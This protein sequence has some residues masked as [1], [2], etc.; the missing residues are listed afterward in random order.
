MAVR[1]SFEQRHKYLFGT[2]GLREDDYLYISKVLNRYGAE[3]IY[4]AGEFEFSTIEELVGFC[5]KKQC[6][7]LL[8]LGTLSKGKIRFS[9]IIG[10]SMSIW[11]VDNPT[12]ASPEEAAISAQTFNEI[13]AR[14]KQR[15]DFIPGFPWHVARNTLVLLPLLLLSST[16]LVPSRAPE[17]NSIFQIT[18]S[19]AFIHYTWAWVERRR[20]NKSIFVQRSPLALR[21]VKMWPEAL[22][23]IFGAAL[24]P[25]CN[26][27]L[28]LVAEK[29]L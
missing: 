25:I 9:L 21:L 11:E 24:G 26:F 2:K 10:G 22:L 23:V 1:R 13:K 27:L 29:I 14:L 28:K 8:A 16:V 12:N 6:N 4:Q 17:T 7:T 19:V 20:W 5:K 18:L 15:Y 3:V